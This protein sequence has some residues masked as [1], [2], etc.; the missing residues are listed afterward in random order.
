MKKKLSTKNSVDA[1]FSEQLNIH[2]MVRFDGVKRISQKTR[3]TSCFIVLIY[4]E[5]NIAV[6]NYLI[7][8]KKSR[9]EKQFLFFYNLTKILPK[10]KKI[11][12]IIC[13]LFNYN[14][15]DYK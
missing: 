14:K 2:F 11:T 8:K 12:P 5:K 7:V 10:S 6:M 4:C 3:F 15:N 13:K 1:L 9:K